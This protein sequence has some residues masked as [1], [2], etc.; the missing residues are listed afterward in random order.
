L[1]LQLSD[2]FHPALFLL[3]SLCSQQVQPRLQ[4]LVRMPS[5]SLRHNIPFCH[6]LVIV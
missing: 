6:S 5:P 4:C 3:L 1:V 2:C